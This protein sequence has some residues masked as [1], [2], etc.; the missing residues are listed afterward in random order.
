MWFIG[1]SKKFTDDTWSSI[2]SVMNGM[3][4]NKNGDK[5]TMQQLQQASMTPHADM[6]RTIALMVSS[7]TDIPVNDLGI[8]MDNPP[9]PKPW[10][11][12]NANCPAP[13]TG[14]TNASAAR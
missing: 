2:V 6:L 9:A 1:A 8:T 14:K 7:E 10:P 3:P 5:P 11:K 4:A 13:P 12:P